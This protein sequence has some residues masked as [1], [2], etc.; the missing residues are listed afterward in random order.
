MRVPIFL[1]YHNQKEWTNL[2]LEYLDRYTDKKLYDLILINNGGFDID[3]SIKHEI[4]KF[5]KKD[6]WEFNI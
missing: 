1:M 4:V 5:D 6:V 2:C 3:C